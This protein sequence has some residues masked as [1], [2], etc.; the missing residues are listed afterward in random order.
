MDITLEHF[1]SELSFS[2]KGGKVLTIAI[3]LKTCLSM[4]R[5]LDWSI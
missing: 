3:Q 1:M 4:T 5:K 2:M